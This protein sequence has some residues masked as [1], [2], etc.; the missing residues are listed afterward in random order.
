MCLRRW[1]NDVGREEVVMEE[2]V[3]W[4]GAALAIGGADT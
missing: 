4:W 1:D 3:M 2:N